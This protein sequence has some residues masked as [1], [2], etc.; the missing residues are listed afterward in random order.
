M[1]SN[2]NTANRSENS[3][4][5]SINKKELQ[6][7]SSRLYNFYVYSKQTNI[8]KVQ[9]EKDSLNRLIED[10]IVEIYA[11]RNH[12]TVSE[13]EVAQRYKQILQ[14]KTESALLSQLNQMYGMNKN[15]YL[16][17]LKTDILREKVQKAVGIPL[18]KWI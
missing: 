9:I 4:T 17:V 3:H 6:T 12:I 5:V 2:Q 8:N 10:K 11:G 15:D 18:S 16:Q 7:E 13:E 1:L 14:T